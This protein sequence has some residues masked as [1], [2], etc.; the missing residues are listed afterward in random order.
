MSISGPAVLYLLCD[1]KQGACLA[2]EQ[3]SA[4]CERE[5][6]LRAS[7]A[8]LQATPALRYVHNPQSVI[9]AIICGQ[10]VTGSLM[11]QG[12]AQLPQ[13]Q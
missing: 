11:P 10:P 7:C 3:Q 9:Y 6:W 8:C 13:V 5:G 2:A 12:C 1:Y 4:S